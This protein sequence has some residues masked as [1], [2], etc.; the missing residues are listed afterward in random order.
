MAQRENISAE[1]G[2]AVHWESHRS[3]WDLPQHHV[4]SRRSHMAARE[5]F[6]QQHTLEP[7]SFSEEDL[8][9][10]LETYDW[11]ESSQILLGT[12]LGRSFTRRIRLLENDPDK[13]FSGTHSYL[14]VDSVG[15]DGV[16]HSI[17]PQA[18]MGDLASAWR[19]FSSTND[20]TTRHHT[21]GKLALVC[22]PTPL[23]LAM[24]HMTHY[25]H[26]DMDTIYADLVNKMIPTTAA[27]DGCFDLDPRRQRSFVFTLK[28][29][30]IIGEGC[31]PM[32]WQ[33][34]E[35]NHYSGG[36]VPGGVHGGYIPV[37]ACSSVFALALSGSPTSNVYVPRANR[38]K[39]ANSQGRC[40]IFDAFSPWHLLSMHFCPDWR[41]TVHQSGSRIDTKYVN[42]PEAFLSSLLLGF[43]DA[44]DRLDDL[45]R[46]IEKLVVPS[47]SLNRHA[48][49]LA[50]TYMPLR[51]IFCSMGN[52]EIS[53]F[54]KMIVSLKLVGF[55]GQAKHSILSIS[56]SKTWSMNMRQPSR[57]RFG[58]GSISIFGQA[59]KIVHPSIP[60]A[61]RECS[62]YAI[63]SNK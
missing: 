34:A 50:N 49:N 57:T 10:H 27:M 22:E 15:L 41:T 38:G 1:I 28:Y 18:V 29:H 23:V 5:T 16:P 12:I 42:G 25:A 61:A 55:P 56:T 39:N 13:G 17:L 11:T 62:S 58:R 4:S 26:F 3:L 40:Q 24:I 30:T 43:Q 48:L 20:S 51:L 35:T 36:S 8:R 60:S 63:N 33:T 31:K 19:V 53:C 59:R 44:A 6:D 32:K 52:F 14:Q 7:E 21:V 47:V 9:V 2:S 37:S 46:R 54:S 45:R